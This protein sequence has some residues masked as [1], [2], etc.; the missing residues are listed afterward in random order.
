MNIIAVSLDAGGHCRFMVDNPV[1]AIGVLREGHHAVAERDV[2]LVALSNRPGA[3]AEVLTLV[4]DAGVNID[5]AYAAAAEGAASAVVV[6]G[7]DD[8][9][10]A[11]TAAGV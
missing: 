4:R 3:L 10:R 2:V 11:A 5:Y 8:A 9:M 1:T 7:V 6:I